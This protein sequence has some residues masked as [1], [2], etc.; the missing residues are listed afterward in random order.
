[1]CI[2]S[3]GVELEDEGTLH[4]GSCKDK[5]DVLGQKVTTGAQRSTLSVPVLRVFVKKFGCQLSFSNSS[6]SST[7][8]EYS[9]MNTTPG[10]LEVK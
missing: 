5:I 3:F 10:L 2:F 4:L 8:S 7:E 9:F 6:D 1:M